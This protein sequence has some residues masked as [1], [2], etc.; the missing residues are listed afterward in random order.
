[1]NI[2][3]LIGTAWNS[4]TVKRVYGEPC[5]KDGVVVIPAATVWGGGGGG[6]GLDGRRAQGAGFGV[7]A[8]PT[9]AYEIKG[10]KVRW[11]PAVDVNRLI[12][13]TAAVAVTY[14]LTRSRRT[15]V[16]SRTTSSGV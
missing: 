9:G 14:L 16:E 5:E 8:H 1:M 2:P 12:T 13:A 3:E 6:D 7:I 15:R 10:G 4:L 11:V